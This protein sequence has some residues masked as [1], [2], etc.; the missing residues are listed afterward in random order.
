MDKVNYLRASLFDRRKGC[1]LIVVNDV[2]SSHP[3][4]TH[5]AFDLFIYLFGIHFL[6]VSYIYIYKIFKFL[7]LNYLHLYGYSTHKNSKYRS[8]FLLHCQSPVLRFVIFL[9]PRI[10]L[11]CPN[12]KPTWNNHSNCSKGNPI[13]PS[14]SPSHVFHNSPQPKPNNPISHQY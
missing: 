1:Y 5:F 14:P 12:S 9:Y 10:I 8:Y 6:N 11:I 4:P 3:Y 7:L 2:I 13:R